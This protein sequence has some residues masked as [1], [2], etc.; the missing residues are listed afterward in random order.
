MEQVA[1]WVRRLRRAWRVC[2]RELPALAWVSLAAYL[3][4]HAALGGPALT[5][6]WAAG[7]H[8]TPEQW[9]YHLLLERLGFPHHHGPGEAGGADWRAG[10]QGVA[11]LLLGAAPNT[12]VFAGPAVPGAAPLL[13]LETAHVQDGCSLVPAPGR[14]APFDL[15]AA[16]GLPAMRPAPPETPPRAGGA[17]A[18]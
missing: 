3:A 9:T 6:A 15:A 8:A 10:D 14:G 13:T 12:T 1:Q 2:L 5:R 11:R 7:G 4:L 17:P 18:A 16:P